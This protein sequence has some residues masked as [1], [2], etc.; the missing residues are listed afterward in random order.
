MSWN[1]ATNVHG[2]R[3][4]AVT[5]PSSLSLTDTILLSGFETSYNL[6]PDTPY[7]QVAAVNFGGRSQ[8]SAISPV[9]TVPAIKA[10]YTE[11]GAVGGIS[12]ELN[13]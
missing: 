5:D 13:F 7:V 9:V 3:I 11:H 8:K 6:N 4:Y 2:W 12:N 1:R 10:E